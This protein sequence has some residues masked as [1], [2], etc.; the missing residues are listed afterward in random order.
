MSAPARGAVV[1]TGCSTGIGRACALGLDRAGF[2]VFAGVRRE[3]D[4]EALRSDASGGLEPLI[5]DVTDGETI[6]AAAARVRE[7]TG[8]RLAGLVNNA[9]ITVGG[10]VE[11]VP[12]DDFRQQLEVN[13]TGQVA[14]TQAFLAMIRGARG[15][16][17]FI[18]SIGGRGGLQ[19]LSPYNASKAALAA[20]GD[21]LRQ[22]MRPFGVGVSIVEPGSIATEIWGKGDDQAQRLSEALDPEVLALYGERI[23]RMRALAA[24]TGATGL[25]AEAVAEV[26]EHALTTPR[27]R[28]RYVV[29]RDAKVQA[30][31]RR[32]LPHRAMD[33]LIEREIDRA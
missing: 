29:G 27:P 33:R 10:P 28:A 14:V 4:G 21:S 9:G 16:V 19:F 8:G 26:V 25:P 11:A 23:D 6:A 22:E 31:A 17:V 32:V 15:R 24:K 5:V 1:I 30:A 18:S 2:T 13:V 7:A 3:A 12:L 20:I